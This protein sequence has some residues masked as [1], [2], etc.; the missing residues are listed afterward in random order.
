MI[1]SLTHLIEIR[2]GASVFIENLY[3]SKCAIY[4]F[5]LHIKRQD[6]GSFSYSHQRKHRE[7]TKRDQCKMKK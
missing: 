4:Y 5:L 6:F 2:V 1:E 3:P 7:R